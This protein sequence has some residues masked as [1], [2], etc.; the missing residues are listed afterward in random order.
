MASVILLSALYDRHVHLCHISKKEEI[1]LIRSAKEKGMKITCE[2]TPHHLFLND[3]DIQ[4]LGN[5]RSQVRPMLATAAD[6]AALW[7][8]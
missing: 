1:E 2:V 6:R 4:K 3:N 5:K 7:H 8:K